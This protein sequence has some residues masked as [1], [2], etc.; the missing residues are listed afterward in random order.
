V[1]VASLACTAAAAPAGCGGGGDGVQAK[2]PS[3]LGADQIDADPIALLPGSAIA[4][5]NVD[6]RAYYANGS[7]GGQ[8][9]KLTERLVPIGDEADF[10]PSR[11]VERIVVASYSTQGLDVAAVVQGHFSADKIGELA[12]K[13][14]PT[15]GGGLVVESQYAG[16]ALYTVD[17]VGFTILTGKTALAGTEAGIRRALDRIRDGRVRRSITPWMI[18]TIETSGAATAVA[19]DLGGQSLAG[20]AVGAVSLDFLNGLKAVRVVG[21]FHDPGMNVAGSLTYATDAQA[22]D[23]ADGLRH[24]SQVAGALAVF[25]VVPRLRNLDIQVVKGNVEAKAA[26]D[27]KALRALADAAASYIGQ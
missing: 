26:V 20:S 19:A 3:D 21:N 15:R 9:G 17:N 1:L 18:E 27:D 8:L 7:L 24:L 10:R 14:T 4:V 16:R 11:D 6:A 2:A 13:H 22:Q 25:G 5:A 12:R 23:G